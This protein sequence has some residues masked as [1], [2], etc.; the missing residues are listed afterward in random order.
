MGTLR[1]GGASVYRKRGAPFVSWQSLETET[2]SHG[3][4][5]KPRCLH[6]ASCHHLLHLGLRDDVAWC[7]CANR[8]PRSHSQRLQQHISLLEVQLPES[9]TVAICNG[10]LLCLERRR[11]GSSSTGGHSDN[12]L[13]RVFHMGD[14]TVAADIEYL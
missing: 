14:L 2:T 9:G 6:A 10:L 4:A 13:F 1:R 11:G 12:S 7:L 8:R 5:H 3:H